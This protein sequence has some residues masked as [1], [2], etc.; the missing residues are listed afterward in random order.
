MVDNFGKI[1]PGQLRNV[2]LQGNGSLEK[3]AQYLKK[4]GDEAAIRK[5]SQDF[6]ALFVQRLMKEMRKSV[7][8]GG[9]MDKSLSMEWFEEMFDQAVAKDISAGEGI[10][11]AEIIYDQLTRPVGEGP[12][13]RL[14]SF[15]ADTKTSAEDSQKP[16]IA[17]DQDSVQ[18][19][20]EKGGTYE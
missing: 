19:P 13:A 8:E 9:L 5:F 4:N 18:R 15:Q 12:S 11:M 10:G 17:S 2:T 1:S 16:K 14:G 6:E 3:E 7:P 20:E